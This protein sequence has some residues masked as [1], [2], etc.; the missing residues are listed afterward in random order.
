[1]KNEPSIYTRIYTTQQLQLPLQGKG[2]QLYA[3]GGGTP[4][5]KTKEL[6]SYWGVEG[7]S[8]GV[9]TSTRRNGIRWRKFVRC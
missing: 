2:Q 8:W 5:Q 4:T 6:Q 3:C 7:G 9:K 1:M